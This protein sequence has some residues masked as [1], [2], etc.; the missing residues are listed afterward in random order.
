MAR[1]RKTLPKNFDELIKKENLSTLI[2]IFDKCELDAYSGYGKVSALGFSHCPDELSKWLV[3]NGADLHYL[4]TYGNTPLHLRAGAIHSN[5]DVLIQMGADVNFQSKAGNTPLHSAVTFHY[6]HNAEVL[7][8]AGAD[9]NVKNEYDLTPLEYS[10]QRCGN[11]DIP[12]MVDMTE[13][14]VRYGVEITPK[15]QELVTAI[16]DKFEFMRED[17]NKDS[18]DEYS[19]ALN[20]L[21][22]LYG[23]TPVATRLLH[24]GQSA[25]ELVG[26][27]WEQTYDNLWDYLVPAKGA[28]LTVQGEVIRIAGRV[29]DELYGNGGVNWD[30]AYRQMCNAYLKHIASHNSLEEKEI[31]ALSNLVSD[32]EMLM[33]ETTQLQQYAVKWISKNTHPIKLETPS[34]KR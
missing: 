13:L 21:Y 1:K 27:T 20:N 11:L 26:D 4:N 31:A 14:F 19:H 32:I 7:L 24:D 28:A 17:F 12:S 9:I 29:T 18:V 33:D 15:M 10:L 22:R 8:A 16:G 2:T 3:D 23:V 25:I 34:Y 6:V 30:R 5:L